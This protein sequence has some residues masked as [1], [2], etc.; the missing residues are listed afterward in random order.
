MLLSEGFRAGEYVDIFDGGPTLVADI[1]DVR[2]VRD[3]CTA[4]IAGIA[5]GG[6]PSIVAAGEGADFR[7]AR[8]C[9][10]TAGTIAPDLA[11]V[12]KVGPGDVIRHIRI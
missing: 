3:S 6:T 12:L 7:V 2:T 8:G 4:W 10:G 1:D 5:E 11:E 9:V